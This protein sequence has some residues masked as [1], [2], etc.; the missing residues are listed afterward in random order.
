[1]AVPWAGVAVAAP[2]G[3]LFCSGQNV[4]RAAYPALFAVL[5]RSTAVTTTIAS[6]AVVTWS[7]H[8]LGAGDPIVF[9]TT[10]A[11]PTGLAA[12]TVY[13]VIAAGLTANS[14]QVSATPGGT[15][16]NTSGSQS[17]IH[18]GWY[19]PY[20]DGDGATTFGIPDLRGRVVAG[21]DAMG[22]TSANR[23]TGVANS[24]DGDVLG[25]TGGEEAHTQTITEL[26]SH[27]HTVIGQVLSNTTTGGAANRYTTGGSVI[28]ATGAAGGGGAHNN[29]QPTVVLN[30]LIFAGV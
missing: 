30:Y 16:I 10:G 5:A 8:G 14:F 25:G 28:N 9:R 13:Y 24:V 19:A 18:T 4:S 7:A 12:G 22:G 20:G 15:A 2:A 27:D 17:G 21:L 1:M 3:W 23:L 6:P 26:V 11:L 29:V